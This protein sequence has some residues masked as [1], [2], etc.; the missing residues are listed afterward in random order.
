MLPPGVVALVTD[1]R[2][3]A[4]DDNPRG[5]FELER[6]KALAKGDTDWVAEA[7]GK[8]IKVI[9]ALLKD[10]PVDEGYRVVFVRRNMGEILASQRRMLANRGEATDRIPDDKLAEMFRHHLAEVETWLARQANF[11]ALYVDYN[12]IVADPAPH[13]AALTAFLG[14]NL[15]A[16]AMRGVVDPTLHRQREAPGGPLYR[17]R[18]Q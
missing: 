2:R 5:Y 7:R 3:A 15:D 4:D 10:L 11:E 8:A 14:G 9:S 17:R 18:P 16:A 1:G 6:V 12:A 13:V